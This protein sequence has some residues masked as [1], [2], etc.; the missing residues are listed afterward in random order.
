MSEGLGSVG[1]QNQLANQFEPEYEGNQQ[2]K[3]D[4][5]DDHDHALL[6]HAVVRIVR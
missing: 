5:Y 6:V 4:A 1:T 3:K 2:H